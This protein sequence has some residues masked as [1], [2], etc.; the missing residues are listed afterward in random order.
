MCLKRRSPQL[1]AVD[2][3][4]VTKRPD[5]IKSVKSKKEQSETSETYRLQQPESCSYGPLWLKRS[6]KSNPPPLYLLALRPTV[7]EEHTSR[8]RFIPW[9]NDKWIKL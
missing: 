3:V 5:S 6:T 9:N 2:S 1:R 4:H 7:R 8:I